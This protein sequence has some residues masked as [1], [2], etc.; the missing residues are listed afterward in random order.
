[1]MRFVP[2]LLAVVL[3]AGCGGDSTSPPPPGTVNV[4]N[5]AFTPSTITVDAGDNVTWHWAS[6]GAPHNVTFAVGPAGAPAN[7][8]NT[9]TGDVVRNF[10]TAGSFA[11]N[12]TIHGAAMSGTVTVL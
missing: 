12:C 9:T 8:P 7:I 11:Y 1:M 2:G 6:G 3:L 5:N 10:T 4:T